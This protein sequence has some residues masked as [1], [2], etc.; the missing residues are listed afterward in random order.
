MRGADFVPIIASG[1]CI[2]APT[3]RRAKT[4]ATHLRRALQA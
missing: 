4:H 3:P 1:L 2:I